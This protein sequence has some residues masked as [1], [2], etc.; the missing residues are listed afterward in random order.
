MSPWAAIARRTRIG[1][2][3]SRYRSRRSLEN[4]SP[5]PI[6]QKEIHEL[7]AVSGGARNPEAMARQTRRAR[8][9]GPSPAA[10]RGFSVERRAARIAEGA[11]AQAE[12]A[13]SGRGKV[14]CRRCP[15]RRVAGAMRTPATPAN[16][17]R[18]TLDHW[19][20]RPP[21]AET[22]IGGAAMNPRRRSSSPR[23][24]SK[25]RVCAI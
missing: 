8:R 23:R 25:G 9:D 15:S 12:A 2:R 11:K 7:C 21:P 3:R 5:S 1:A 18:C 6:R 20:P 24:T 13:R 16:H 14:K 10:R 17:R 22:E 19:A 4:D